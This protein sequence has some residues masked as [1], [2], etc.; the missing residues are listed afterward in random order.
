[1]L[2][3]DGLTEAMAPDGAL[4]GR[5]TIKSELR[6]LADATDV[7]AIGQQLLAAVAVFE[8]GVDPA[9]DQTLILLRWPGVAL[10]AR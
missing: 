6:Q 2:L 3:S 4:L 5:E 9:D 7:E 1:M 8:A 10:S